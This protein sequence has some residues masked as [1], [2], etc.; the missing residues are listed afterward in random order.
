LP[1][2]PKLL[3]PYSEWVKWNIHDVLDLLNNQSVIMGIGF[4]G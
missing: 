1:V 2:V 3:L 4:K